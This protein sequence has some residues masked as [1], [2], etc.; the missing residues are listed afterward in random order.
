ML[1]VTHAG[2]AKNPHPLSS[3]CLARILEE[4]RIGVLQTWY[5]SVVDGLQ[6]V[7]LSVG[8]WLRRN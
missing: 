5:S 2:R 4:C 3:R 6:R 7:R 8:M 1:K